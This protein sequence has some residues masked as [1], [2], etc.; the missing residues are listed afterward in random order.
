MANYTRADLSGFVPQHDSFVGIDS[1]GCVFDTMEVKQKQFFHGRI[2][3]VWR[4]APIERHVRQ[5]AEFVNLY[6]RTR[7]SNRFEALLR[8]FELLQQ[9]PDAVAGGAPL[10]DTT[11]LR[12]YV[13]S[14]LPLGNP[15][16]QAEVKR[17]GN[18]ELAR[19]LDWSLAV[20][21]DIAAGMPA[22]PPFRW[23]RESLE[24]I[25]RHSDAI[26][27]SQ[28]PEEALLNEWRQHG[29][30][31]YVR[32][33]AGQ[34]LGTKAEQ[35]RL[36]TTGRYAPERVLLIGDSL[37]DLSAARDAGV[38]FYPI[39]PG[40]EDA[41]WERFAQES[42]GRF[43]DGAYAGGYEQAL[44]AEFEGLLPEHPPWMRHA[45]NPS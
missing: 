6:S 2:V 28:T 14:G 5:A 43:R 3:S 8:V 10:P 12:E 40:C 18:P 33:I 32:I 37:N 38:L 13:H 4:L 9:W 21:A 45:Q 15:T 27:V 17:T 31:T 22:I 39:R 44:V 29:L 20:N 11:A 34:E 19:L 23:A 1:D 36:A 24:C 25:R 41:S 42:Y 16:L 7:G 26:V 30:E 35:L